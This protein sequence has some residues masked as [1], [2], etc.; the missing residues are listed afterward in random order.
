MVPRLAERFAVYTYDRRG[1]GDSGDHATYAVEREIEDLAAVISAAG[2]QAYVFG[3][4]SGAALAAHAAA[5]GVPIT[6]LTLL[7]PVADLARPASA[8]S[9]LG[10]EVA[11]MVEDGRRGEAFLHFNRSVGV[12][13]DMVRSLPELP[14]W[15]QLEALAHTLVYDTLIT[16]SVTA[17]LLGRVHVPTLVVDS[18]GSDATLHEFSERVADAMPHAVHRRMP[19]GWHLADE[20][21]LVAEIVSHATGS[22]DSRR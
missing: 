3:F 13:E 6:G 15:P 4:S 14:V 18:E 7:E 19:G 2:G 20:A 10:N 21:L 8:E 1:R 17:E 9:E 22:V 16:G 11:E 12:P 5:D